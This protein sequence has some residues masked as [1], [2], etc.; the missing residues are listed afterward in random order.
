MGIC[1]DLLNNV[2]Q[3]K[4]IQMYGDKSGKGFKRAENKNI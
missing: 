2:P 4:C 1:F 3:T